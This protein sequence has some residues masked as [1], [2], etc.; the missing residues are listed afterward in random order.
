M[1]IQMKNPLSTSLSP[2]PSRNPRKAPVADFSARLKVPVVVD[3]F[4]CHGSYKWPQN[5]SPRPYKDADDEPDGGSPGTSL[6][7]ACA[8]GKVDRNQVVHH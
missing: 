3:Q 7:A 2:V 8:L 1:K 5:Y 6:A 4:S